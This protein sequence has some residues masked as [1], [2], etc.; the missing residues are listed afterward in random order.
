MPPD[1]QPISPADQFE[2]GSESPGNIEAAQSALASTAALG[3]D[4][5]PVDPAQV[6]RALETLHKLPSLLPLIDPAAALQ[7]LDALPQFPG[8]NKSV[9]L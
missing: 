2:S 6:S 7:A 4:H 5:S 3:T 9:M 8:T 1:A